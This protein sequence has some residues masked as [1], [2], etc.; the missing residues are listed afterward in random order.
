M[1]LMRLGKW[2]NRTNDYWRIIN[3]GW[4]KKLRQ[5]LIFS[6]PYRNGKRQNTCG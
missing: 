6:L 1:Q 4:K 2:E 5:T 3:Y